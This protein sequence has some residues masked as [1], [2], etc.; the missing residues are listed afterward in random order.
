MDRMSKNDLFKKYKKYKDKSNTTVILYIHMPD[1][2][3]EVIVNSNAY[4]KMD[5]I[6]KTYDDALTHKLSNDIYIVDVDFI[7]DDEYSFGN[8]LAVMRMGKRVARKGWNGKGMFCYFVPAGKFEPYTSV[9]LTHCINDDG[10]VPY[11][12]YIA[13]KT[14]DGTIVPWLASQMDMLAKDWYTVE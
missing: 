4:N 9:A 1:D 13:I 2:S 10:K 3:I 5:Y 8:A 7:A 12:G 6:D 14:V 11:G